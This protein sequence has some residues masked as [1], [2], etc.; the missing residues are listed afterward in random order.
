MA[1][2]AFSS[3]TNDTGY[4]FAMNAMKESTETS[5][6]PDHS[7]SSPRKENGTVQTI[8]VYRR[9][10]NGSWTRIIDQGVIVG[11]AQSFLKVWDHKSKEG[12]AQSDNAEWFPISSRNVKC[13]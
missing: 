9:S 1:A 8:S 2:S 6:G 10:E 7:G 4:H 3:V 5:T 11:T 13:E 12:N